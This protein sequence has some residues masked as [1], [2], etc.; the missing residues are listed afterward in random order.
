MVPVYAGC[1]SF[2]TFVT[3][4]IWMQELGGNR[5]EASVAAYWSCSVEIIGYGSSLD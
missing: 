5:A 3:I 2:G 4:K 1:Y